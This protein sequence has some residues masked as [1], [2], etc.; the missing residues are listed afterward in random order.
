MKTKN[1]TW[2]SN[3]SHSGIVIL[4]ASI[5]AI[6]FINWLPDEKIF[7][8]VLIGLLVSHTL[9][10]LITVFGGWLLLPEK[11]L[12]KFRK[13]RSSDSFDFG[14]SSKW[15]KGFGYAAFICTLLAFYSFYGLNG[16]PVIQILVF[17]FLL[18]LSV[19]LF[20]G[21]TIAR[22]SNNMNYV[23][24]P[25]VD[26]FKAGKNN[27]LDAGCGAGRTT[28][29]LSK[30]EPDINI[31]AFD[32]YDA[33]YID[34]GGKNLLEKN[35]ELAGLSSRVKIEQ[36][37][38]TAMPFNDSSFDA[39]VSSYM[40]DH[41]GENRLLALKEMWRVLKPG[42]RFL[43]IVI[44][45][46]NSAFAIASILSLSF[47]TRNDWKKSFRQS[48]FNIIDEGNINFGAYFLIEKPLK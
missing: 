6:I 40:F 3:H 30:A 19:N 4:A 38:I 10:L 22:A 44:V 16:F 41:L 42:G 48:G 29:S 45:R 46:G 47:Q 37:D 26:L 9:I 18:L 14:W 1:Q 5:L 17:T 13:K 34:D 21:N 24:L 36:G 25:Y 39:S 20:I 33:N 12:K 28:I 15:N 11:I 32:R 35:L 27:V 31:V 7:S 8:S 43:L 23:V 2:F